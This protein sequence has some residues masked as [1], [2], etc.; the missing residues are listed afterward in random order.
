MPNDIWNNVKWENFAF[1]AIKYDISA[2]IKTITEYIPEQRPTKLFWVEPVLHKYDIGKLEL[3][4]LAIMKPLQFPGVLL[5]IK[6]VLV[7]SQY[8][9][10]PSSVM[11]LES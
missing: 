3:E 5:L 2:E 8:K 9:Q 7:K 6:N 1:L 10:L 11:A 4:E